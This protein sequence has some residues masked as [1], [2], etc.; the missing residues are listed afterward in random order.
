M[1][2]PFP[3]SLASRILLILLGGLTFSH[4]L[5][6]LV[7]TSE[8]LEPLVLTNEEQV[9]ERMA[10]VT[11]LL[12]QLPP[13]LRE[14]VLATL[15]HSGLH[16]ETLRHT[17]EATPRSSGNN[18]GLQRLLAEKIG[19]DRILVESVNLADIDWNHR[20]G[21]LHRLFFALEMTLIRTMHDMVMDRVL[22]AQVRLPDGDRLIMVTRPEENHV[23]LF[24]H[25]TLSVTIMT[26]GILL[27]SLLIA[28][29]LTA[30][31]QRIAQA[32]DQMGRDIHTPPLEE[33][34]A[35]EVVSVARAFN[36]MNRNI[37]D[38]VAERLRLLAAISHDLRT[39]LTKLKLMA[40][41]VGDETLRGRMVATLDEMEV[42]LSATL[43]MARDAAR[44]EAKQKVNLSGLL[45]AICEDLQDAG[46]TVSWRETEK[47]PCHCRPLAMKRALTNLI[48]NAVIYGGSA[49]VCL[50][51]RG[52]QLLID[53]RD[54]GAGIPESEWENVFKPFL[55]LEPSRSPDTGGVGLGLSIAASILKDHDG[56]I[57]FA[58]PPEGGFLT[59]VVLPDYP[60]NG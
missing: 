15:N 60:A 46:H 25:A 30:P 29:N 35:R 23:P 32:A 14:P 3:L 54:P 57:Q 55:R 26:G 50:E 16:V 47:R 51:R 5:S 40:E 39:P 44:A 45:Q 42:M 13:T 19:S 7:F 17:P 56:T 33:K 2:N 1:K 4:L 20:H 53:I 36:R 10:T 58:H 28:R 9:L 8:K 31:L 52:E 41:F 11:R 43:S 49:R 6:I 18:P 34:G 21:N 38:F 22:S 27:F 59:R 12:L 24:R 48:H 37:R